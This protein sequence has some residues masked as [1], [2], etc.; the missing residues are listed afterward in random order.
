MEIRPA[1]ETDLPAITALYHRAFDAEES[2]DVAR[3]AGELTSWQ[4]SPQTY[5]VLAVTEG[6]IVGHIAFS[7]VTIE[8]ADSI[9]A[10]NLAPLAVDPDS[11]KQGV[12]RQLIQWGLDKLG[13][14]GCQLVLVYGDPNYY[15]RFGFRADIG[16]FFLPAYTLEHAFGWQGL[17]IN[18]Y[19]YD[20]PVQTIHCVEPLNKPELW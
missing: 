13:A 12:G 14:D 2:V 1:K 16:Q 9:L 19:N 17:T 15:G 4:S 3:L 18:D 11:Q 8:G 20:G 5:S 7:P 10:Y 6:A